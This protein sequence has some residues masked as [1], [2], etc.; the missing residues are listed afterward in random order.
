M[1]P[2]L[3][4]YWDDEQPRPLYCCHKHAK[5]LYTRAWSRAYAL[6]NQGRLHVMVDQVAHRGRHYVEV[7]CDGMQIVLASMLDVARLFG[8][9]ER[10]W[11]AVLEDEMSFYEFS[12]NA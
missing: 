6:P 9:I 12:Q 3:R 4:D 5:L 7:R 2:R 8:A 11:A 1:M 10:W